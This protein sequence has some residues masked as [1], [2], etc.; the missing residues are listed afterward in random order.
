M[1]KS[2]D[3]GLCFSSTVANLRGIHTAQAGLEST[4]LVLGYGL[5]LFYTRVTPSRMFDVLKEDF[6]Y[7]FVGGTLI[8]LLV[9]SILSCRLASI[10]MLKQAWH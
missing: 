3:Q 9:I 1:A 2:I 5:D 7:M 10:K 4:S 8:V 6:D